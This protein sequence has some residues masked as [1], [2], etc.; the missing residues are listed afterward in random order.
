MEYLPLSRDDNLFKHLVFSNYTGMPLSKGRNV[1]KARFL[2]ETLGVK[3]IH[4]EG[5]L[6]MPPLFLLGLYGLTCISLIKMLLVNNGAGLGWITFNAVITFATLALVSLV[7]FTDPG[8]VSHPIKSFAKNPICEVCF[9]TKEEKCFHCKEI[10]ICVKDY[11][12]W[13]SLL[14]NCITGKNAMLLLWIA[15]L[16][17]LQIIG[18]V[19]F[20]I[21]LKLR[22]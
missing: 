17:I 3:F 6:S 7:S 19:G 14:G 12:F 4:F 1:G 21:K 2:Y 18:L 5:S 9:T 22:I 16:V 20:W 11:Y 10:A 13:S 8:F 15:S